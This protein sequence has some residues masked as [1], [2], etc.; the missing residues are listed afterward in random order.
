MRPVYSQA[1]PDPAGLGQHFEE[2][3]AIKWSPAVAAD[4]LGREGFGD[5]GE[6]VRVGAELGDDLVDLLLFGLGLG[7]GFGFGDGFGVRFGWREKLS[8]YFLQ[9]FDRGRVRG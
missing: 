5:A 4:V 9:P 8:R 6:G 1:H 3:A 2:E 7:G